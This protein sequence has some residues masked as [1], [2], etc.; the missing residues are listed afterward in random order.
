MFCNMKE[1]VKN[2]FSEKKVI[3]I[4]EQDE[5]LG[6][7]LICKPDGTFAIKKLNG[8]ELPLWLSSM[9]FVGLEG[10]EVVECRGADGSSSILLENGLSDETRD[11]LLSLNDP[12][13]EQLLSLNTKL[14]EQHEADLREISCIKGTLEYW[15]RRAKEHEFKQEYSSLKSEI[16]NITRSFRSG[17]PFDIENI[18]AAKVF[19]VGRSGPKRLFRRDP[20]EE[21]AI[22]QQKSG[23]IGVFSDFWSV[24]AIG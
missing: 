4:T 6:G 13:V 8:T 11:A 10:F 2:L 9:R 7:K 19:N 20:Y 21:F 22:I 15:R 18:V 16:A 5:K 12:M 1:A 3:V 24:Y 23:A 17:D 14:K